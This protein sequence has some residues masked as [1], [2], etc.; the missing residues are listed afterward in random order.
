MSGFSVVCVPL[1]LW[2]SG[3]A[4][5]EVAQ[6]RQA[7]LDLGADQ[8]VERESAE[9]MLGRTDHV[10]AMLAV[11]QFAQISDP[12]VRA[13]VMRLIRKASQDAQAD[14]LA[15]FVTG[16]QRRS[17]GETLDVRQ[18]WASV[19]AQLHSQCL[20]QIRSLGGKVET[21]RPEDGVALPR[22]TLY[23]GLTLGLAGQLKLFPRVRLVLSGPWIDDSNVRHLAGMTNLESLDMR[24][25]QISDE[26]I[27][28]IGQL[29]RLRKLYLSRTGVTDATTEVISQL[30][31]LEEL[32]VSDTRLTD[33]SVPYLKRLQKL[34]RLSIRGT[35][36]TPA[37]ADALQRALPDCLIQY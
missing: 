22:I 4:P 23:K 27:R 13:R 19:L 37:R 17:I 31:Q 25:T 33:Q 3:Y 9:R 32:F 34:K 6:Y 2:S 36:I 5:P 29:H 26:G 21:E 7:V 28:S 10:H 14:H 18:A 11:A 12:E 20:R 35:K 15:Q 8:F 24:F 1:L 16:V 30:D